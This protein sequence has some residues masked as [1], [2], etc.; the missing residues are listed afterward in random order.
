[1]I[2]IISIGF[3]SMEFELSLE[4]VWK[5]VPG[6]EG[7]YQVSDQGRVKS[8]GRVVSGK[9][10]YTKTDRILLPSN[11]RDGYKRVTLSK[12]CIKEYY[13]IHRLVLTAFVG[14]ND[15]KPIACHCDGDR[16]N[17]RLDN[18]RWD[19][20]QGNNDDTLKYGT[21]LFGSKSTNH[22]LDEIDVL[23]MRFLLTL[24]LSIRQIRTLFNVSYSCVK[25]IEKGRSWKHVQIEGV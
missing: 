9:R 20:T 18:L 16:S 19:T 3:L 7:Y 25:H 24:K 5:D 1:M 4:E 11:D 23:M 10:P 2:K 12:D 6:Y 8:L 15:D 13:S 17:N 14:V 21:R 22:L